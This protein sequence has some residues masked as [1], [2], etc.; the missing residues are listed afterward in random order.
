MAAALHSFMD[1]GFAGTSTLDIA[2]SAKVSKRDLYQVATSKSELLRQAVLDRVS[3]LHAP[4]ELPLAAGPE[5]FAAALAAFGC[6]VMAGVCAHDVLALYR[7]AAA[8][9]ADNTQDIAPILDALHR[10]A[11][12]AVLA[13]ALARA[14]ADGL[15]EVGDTA[16][17]AGDFMALLWED[18]LLRL[19]LRLADPPRQAEMERRAQEAVEKFLRLHG[20]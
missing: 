14:Q 6:A 5:A 2:S 16:A 18:L 10:G 13:R 20:T 3:R 1:R 8:E 11:G 9:A 19:V 7:F 15:V 12:R 17:Q 4:P